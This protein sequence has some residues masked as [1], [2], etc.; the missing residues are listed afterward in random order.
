MRRSTDRFRAAD[1]EIR[2]QHRPGL[3]RQNLILSAISRNKPSAKLFA[4]GTH[5]TC[6]DSNMTHAGSHVG[7]HTQNA[8]REGC[9]L[10]MCSKAE[11]DPKQKG[12]QNDAAKAE[13][14]RTFSDVLFLFSRIV[15]FFGDDNTTVRKRLLQRTGLCP[16]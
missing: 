5:V 3:F 8:T 13:D 14:I 10:Q 9:S 2:K 12:R 11:R 7:Q 15:C 4:G 6:Q 16:G 1:L